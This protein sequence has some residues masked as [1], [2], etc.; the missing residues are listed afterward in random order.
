MTGIP[1]LR[2]A[3]RVRG[4]AKGVGAGT[5][6]AIYS[7]AFA[8]TA[9]LQAAFPDSA[10]R[11]LVASRLVSATSAEDPFI[12][13]R[14]ALFFVGSVLAV[15]VSLVVF[16][17][18]FAGTDANKVRKLGWGGLAFLSVVLPLSWL[19]YPAVMLCR[20]CLVANDWAYAGIAVGFFLALNVLVQIVYLKLKL[21]SGR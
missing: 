16:R 8:L 7:G 3:D 15:L 12:R 19:G 18:G 20:N 13:Y 10:A 11:L 21:L 4:A 9:W 2:A 6:L 1:E 17:S 5:L 14:L